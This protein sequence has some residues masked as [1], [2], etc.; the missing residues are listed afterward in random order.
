MEAKEGFTRPE[1][2]VDF[3]SFTAGNSGQNV[4]KMVKWMT[5]NEIKRSQV[6]SITMNETDIEEG[7]NMLTLW[8]RE[9]PVA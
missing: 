4:E 3:V 6:V 1:T 8:Y 9:N 2:N 5:E 7:Q